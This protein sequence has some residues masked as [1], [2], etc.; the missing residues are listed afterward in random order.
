M[1]P[2]PTRGDI[3]EANLNPTRGHE[4]GG[5]RPVLIISVDQFN[6]GPAELVFAVPISTKDKKVRSQVAIDPPEGGLK[7]R[8]F[9]KCE[10]LRSISTV[11]LTQRR[12]AVSDRTIREVET[13]LRFLMGL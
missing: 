9:A 10:A 6:Q 11:R 5:T 1:T 4:Q 8:S 3:W 13:R 7:E 2:K 12:G